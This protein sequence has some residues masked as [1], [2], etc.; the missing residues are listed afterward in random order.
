MYLYQSHFF[1]DEQNAKSLFDRNLVGRKYYKL[2]RRN[3]NFGCFDD[4]V[5]LNA[6]TH[7]FEQEF[8]KP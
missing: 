3:E 6:S 7:F 8:C 4:A 1:I 5:D 2:N